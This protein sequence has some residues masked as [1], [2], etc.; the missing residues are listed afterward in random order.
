MNLVYN[1]I[2]QEII[3]A[4][5]WAIFHSLWQG[6]LISI[7][8]GVVLLIAGKKSAQLRYNFSFTSLVVIFILSV[9]TFIEVY[10]SSAENVPSNLEVLTTTVFTNP[11]FVNDTAPIPS[12]AN[13][14]LIKILENS[15]A[16]HIPL[17]VSIWLMGFILFSMRFIGGVLYVQ[18]LRTIDIKPLDDLWNLR[19]NGL[20]N[21][22]GINKS[23]HIFES[24]KVKVP[25]ALGYLKPMILLPVGMLSG[26]PQ[27]Q[28][29]AIVIHELA[30]IKRYDFLLNLFQTIIETLFF[31]HP[32]VWWITS[33]LKNERE[34][35]CDD[36]TL[37]LCGGSLVYFKALYNLQQI[38]SEES[39][40]VLAAIGKRNQLFRRINRMNSNNRTT[41]YGVKFA[42]FACVLIILA[43]VSV[44]ST[45]SAKD[46]PGNISIAGFVNPFSSDDGKTSL[47]TSI[48]E[49]IINH[50][51]LSIK[52][53]KRTLKFSDDDKRYKAKLNE[54]KL[55]ELY[56]DGD[57]VDDKELSKYESVV[58]RQL[59]EYDAAMSEY[60]D[61]MKEFKEKM[62]AFRDKIKKFRGSRDFAFDE[63]F[64]PMISPAP[65]FPPNVDSAEWNKMMK[66]IQKNINDN[67]ANKS[68]HIPPIHIP[69]I[70]IPKINWDSTFNC[71]SF[72]REAFKES[73][74]EWK[75]KFSKEMDGFNKEMSKHKVEMEKMKEEIKNSGI[76]SPEFKKSM[77]KLKVNIGKLKG[78]MKTLKEYLHDVKD[79][80]VK[81]NLIKEGDD[82]DGF[83]LSKTEMK[84]NGKKVSL[85]LHKKYLEIYKKHY[86]KDL[87][88]DQKINFND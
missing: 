11:L 7:L 10:N 34:N 14:S 65:I 50:D 73:M 33:L 37:K 54:G 64:V 8:L 57:K 2:P 86:G 74:K 26:L 5:G 19:L 53:G 16:Q 66:N 24:V 80:F 79:E 25:V 70:H 45:S 71:N 15:F 23:I 58:A 67:F 13:N 69:P 32:V 88:D 48:N 9:A 46:L 81:D 28:V 42:V 47:T 59:K 27:D 82:L 18:R 22:I 21:K 85:E 60:C 76:N 62:K 75:E 72:D 84:V 40:F 49:S 17:V 43:A 61:N 78:D 63:D 56:I 31:F 36:L 68:F 1:F 83:L 44:Y 38:Y 3:K 20:S 30:H 29:E 77:E 12:T 52:K 39:E 41:S 51:T 6:A 35:C 4:I 55:E 87:K